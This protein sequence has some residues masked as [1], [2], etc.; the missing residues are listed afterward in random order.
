MAVARLALLPQ[1]VP[2]QRE[3]WDSSVS[4]RNV[5]NSSILRRRLMYLQFEDGAPDP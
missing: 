5:R 1:I 3:K 4:D 2:A